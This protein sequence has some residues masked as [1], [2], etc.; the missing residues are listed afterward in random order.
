MKTKSNKEIISL[1]I[2]IYLLL[3]NVFRIVT[4][5]Y[6]YFDFIKE[7]K[8]KEN[9]VIFKNLEISFENFNKREMLE[10]PEIDFDSFYE[11][12]KPKQNP[13]PTFT[14]TEILALQKIA[15]AEAENEGIGGM[16]FVMQTVINRVNDENFPDTIEE[17]ISQKGQ[18]TTY[19]NGSYAKANPTENSMKAIE[20]LEILENKGQTFFE[21]KT[22]KPTWQ[23]N[24]LTYVFTYNNHVFYI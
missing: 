24:N 5:G 16:S 23:S 14:A 11:N 12:F 9:F 18:F 4:S 2:V 6:S 1:M 19:A 13:Q 17:V 15:I 8:S 21:A 20:L 22:E 10:I 3:F 7:T